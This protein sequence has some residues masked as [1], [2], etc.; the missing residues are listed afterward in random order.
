MIQVHGQ[1]TR[2]PLLFML[3]ALLLVSGGG[4]FAAGSVAG[5]YNVRDYGAKGDG[6][7]LDSPAI[8]KAIDTAALAGG[9]TVRLPAGTYLSTSIHLK[10]NIALYI[11]QGAT[12]KSAPFNT[13]MLY[14]APEAN[15]AAADFQDYGHTHFQNSLI[16][17]ENLENVSILGPGPYLGRG[18][19]QRRRPHAWQRQQGHQSE[20][21][22]QRNYARFHDSARRLVW[23]TGNGR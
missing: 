20:A 3:G 23:D 9:G 14:D 17:G 8:N 11:D 5:T 4:V 7:T 2:L 6:T 16:W 10:S 19:G 15:P 1:K 12:L 22:P 18:A 21:V 13:G